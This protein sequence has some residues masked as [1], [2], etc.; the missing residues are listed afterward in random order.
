MTMTSAREAGGT[1]NGVILDNAVREVYSKE[2]L[3]NAQPMLLFA[4]FAAY[5]NDLTREAGDTIKFTKYA[6]L[7]GDASL[8]EVE[9]ISHTNLKASQIAIE[10]QEYGKGVS[11][12]EKLIRTGWDDVVARATMLL[13]QHYGRH[14]DS[15]IRN[16]YV[17]AAS[18]QQFYSLAGAVNRST[19]ALT[20][21]FNVRMVKD[22]AERL[23]TNKT[24][25]FGDAYICVV[26][27]HQ[28][29]G[30]RDD[31]DW[32][33]AHKYASPEE[34]FN[35]EIGRV[36]GVR[37]VETTN[38]TTVRPDGTVWADNKNTGLTEAIAPAAGVTTYQSM[39]IGANAVGFA[40]ALPVEFRMDASEDYGRTRKM[41]WYGIH[42]VGSIEDQ[43]VV[44][45]ESA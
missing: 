36:E 27:P 25:K 2:I 16:Q 35:G 32:V 15:L 13:G 43:N 11:E 29:R 19:L 31:A 30:I 5:Q 40:E 23:A 1:K 8:S 12:S 44:G 24:P 33:E 22:A 7:E 34:I 21:T 10:V 41:A 4:Q 39:V 26:H 3:F 17:A 37:F 42:G 38:I 28:S 45:L 18:L 20:D 6:D 14:L 9:L